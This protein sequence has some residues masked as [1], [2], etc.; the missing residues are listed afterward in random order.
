MDFDEVAK[1]LNGKSFI[2]LLV[3]KAENII[4]NNV[5]VIKELVKHSDRGIFVTLNQPYM[6][7]KKLLEKNHINFKDI[8]FI[9]MIT[10]TASLYPKRIENCLFINSPSD[11]TAL[12]IAVDQALKSMNKG[13]RFLFIDNLAIFLIYNDKD[14]VTEFMHYLVSKMRLNNVNGVIMSVQEEIGKDFIEKVMK[15]FCDDI[16]ELN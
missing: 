14:M 8:F 15:S 5:K 16:I 9:D 12:G 13:T 10:A 7:F 3:S 11:L 2:L 4:K 1:K 6:S